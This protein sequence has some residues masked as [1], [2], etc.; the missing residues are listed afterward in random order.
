MKDLKENPP[1]IA[2]GDEKSVALGG[3]VGGINYPL[4][5]NQ[6]IYANNIMF[7]DLF[8]MDEEARMKSL[9]KEGKASV[10][11]V[12]MLTKPVL[13][14]LDEMI[15][16]FEKNEEDG[17][18]L[19]LRKILDEEENGALKDDMKRNCASRHKRVDR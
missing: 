8:D 4:L 18:D 10:M 1:R 17:M 2:E 19:G 12:P 3:K 16:H 5:Y 14:H 13:S 9:P 6:I 15:E 11:S 7:A